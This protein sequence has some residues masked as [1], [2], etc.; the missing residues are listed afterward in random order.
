M[1]ALIQRVSSAAVRVNGSEVARIGQG[2]VILLGVGHGDGAAQ[3]QFLV[4]KIA[5]LRIFED[6]DGKMNLSLPNIKGQA[7]DSLYTRMRARAGGHLL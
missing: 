5:N 2:T 6:D 7:I 3:A 1:K 4:E